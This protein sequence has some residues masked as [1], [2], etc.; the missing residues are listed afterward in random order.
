MTARFSILLKSRASLTCF[1][2]CF[3]P[4][5]A[6]DLSAPGMR[7]H[8]LTRKEILGSNLAQWHV[9]KQKVVSPVF[10]NVGQA[11]IQKLESTL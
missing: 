11:L 6:K 3:L 4:V 2:A 10:V 9:S 8:I 5:R 1:R 7:S